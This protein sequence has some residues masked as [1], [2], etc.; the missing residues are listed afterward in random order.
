MK[1]DIF[2]G[3]HG[4]FLVFILV[5]IFIIADALTTKNTSNILW[6]AFF[7]I[8]GGLC[9]WNY[10]ILRLIANISCS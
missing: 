9:L 4:C 2:T 5:A 8:I 1:R 7:F 10:N 3:S 6:T